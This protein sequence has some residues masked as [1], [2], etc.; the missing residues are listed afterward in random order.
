V[1]ARRA[2][3]QQFSR[4]I[5]AP[6]LD[7]LG[8]E[9]RHADLRDPDRTIGHGPDLLNLCRPFVDRPQVPIERKPVHRDRI[10][11][12]EHTFAGHVGDKVR[13]DG[14]N[15]AENARQRRVGVLHGLAGGDSHLGKQ[16]PVGIYL[17]IPMGLVVRLVP[18]HDGF[19]HAIRSLAG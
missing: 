8:A 11:V 19:D 15:A 3:D 16:R 5:E 1:D 4:A 7:L 6:G 9:A 18:D 13:I 2:A 12:I 17:G 14:R 10:D